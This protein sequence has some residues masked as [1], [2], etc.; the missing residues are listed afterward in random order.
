MPSKFC[1]S[2]YVIQ[3]W[4]PERRPWRDFL[5]TSWKQHVND[6][7]T[8][9]FVFH[10]T[11]EGFQ[12]RYSCLFASCSC[13]LI[14]ALL[15]ALCVWESACMRVW[16]LCTFMTITE[17]NKLVRTAV[18]SSPV[19]RGR[20]SSENDH[21]EGKGLKKGLLLSSGL[22]WGEDTGLKRS[23]LLDTQTQHLSILLNQLSHGATEH[24][25]A[26]TGFIP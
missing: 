17:I 18:L 13:S 16:W 21:T 2:S 1:I 20:F 22:N 7:Y 24:K 3:H 12:G 10:V 15:Y 4:F 8:A 5:S 9:L 23:Y 14:H 26:N 11:S 25:S 6:N 19:L